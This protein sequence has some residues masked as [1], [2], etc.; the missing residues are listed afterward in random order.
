MIEFKLILL[1]GIA[2]GAPLFTNMV[3]GSRVKW[4]ID[5]LRLFIDGQPLFGKTKTWRGLLLSLMLTTGLAPLLGFSWQLG[6]GFASCA[7]LGDL[8]SSFTK[9]RLRLS[10]SS[11]ALG[12]D[13]IPEALLPL[14]VFKESLN[15]QWGSILIVVGGFLIAELLVSKLLFKFGL[16]NRPY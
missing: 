1:I 16:R 15:I 13:Q 8:F 9:R 11:Q 10:P 3:F 5:G 7:M 12:L 2:N 6:A 14:I 4:P